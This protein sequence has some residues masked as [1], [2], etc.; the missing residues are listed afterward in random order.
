[1]RG[2]VFHS[3]LYLS[4]SSSGHYTKLVLKYVIN[5]LLNKGRIYKSNT[6][7]NTMQ[8]QN[9]KESIINQNT[10][11]NGIFKKTVKKRH[12]IIYN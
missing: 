5:A 7:K 6:W 2:S 1:M 11:L 4:K 12:L 9:K 3:A 10:F 8:Q